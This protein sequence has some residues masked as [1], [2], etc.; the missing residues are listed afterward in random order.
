MGIVRKDGA[1][2][3]KIGTVALFIPFLEPGYAQVLKERDTAISTL[4]FVVV[5]MWYEDLFVIIIITFETFCIGV[6][7]Y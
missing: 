7:D 4:G 6:D 3:L 1:L 2:S 5:A